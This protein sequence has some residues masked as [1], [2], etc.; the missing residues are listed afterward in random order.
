MNG[1]SA[2]IISSIQKYE[3]GYLSAKLETAI[4]VR[5]EWFEK[6][7]FLEQNLPAVFDPSQKYTLKKQISECD[8]KIKECENEIL[9]TI[10]KSSIDVN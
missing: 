4:N 6:K 2:D 9:S 5:N 1:N 10:T 7:S 3:D 8:T